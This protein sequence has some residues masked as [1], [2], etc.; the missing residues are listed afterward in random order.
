[1]TKVK[2]TWWEKWLA[3]EENGTDSDDS[4]SGS[5]RKNEGNGM[6]DSRPRQHVGEEMLDV[7]MVFMM[8]AEFW[9]P[10]FE[11]VEL[12]TEAERAIFE[13]LA[14]SGEHMK[15]LYIRGLLDGTLVGWMMLD[16]GGSVNILPLALF[17]KLGH[18]EGDLKRANKCLSGFSREPAEDK[19]IVSKELTVGSKKVPTAFFVVDVKGWYNVLLGRDWMHANSC[20]PSMLHHC[21]VQWVGDSV[22]VIEADESECVVMNES[23][24]NVQGGR[25]SC[26]I[27]HDHTDYDYVSVSK[28][29]DDELNSASKWSVINGSKDTSLEWLTRWASEY[30]LAEDGIKEVV[31]DFDEVGK[32]RQGFRWWMNLRK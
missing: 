7:N 12:T 8:P 21:I 2:R 31:K 19:G 24:A 25:M 14:R 13:K 17:K 9:A 3:K 15:P 16:S 27:G 1:M 32:L 6:M 4:Q 30:H 5:E 22:E 23:Q 20:V 18:S 26:L 10:E 29:V 11:V 28:E